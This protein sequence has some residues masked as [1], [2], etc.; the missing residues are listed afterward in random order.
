VAARAGDRG[1][2]EPDVQRPLLV[3]WDDV[4]HP[5]ELA[6]AEHELVAGVDVVG[7]CGRFLQKG[8]KR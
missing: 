2:A 8:R 1:S 4:E 3:D 7:V 6:G 5:D